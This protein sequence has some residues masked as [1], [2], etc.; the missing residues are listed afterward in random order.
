MII[1][2]IC[3][4]KLLENDELFIFHKVDR[5]SVRG[6][7]IK[8]PWNNKCEVLTLFDMKIHRVEGA[9]IEVTVYNLCLYFRIK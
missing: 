8:F 9:M 4:I 6:A 3:E 7:M 1:D 2:I 5:E